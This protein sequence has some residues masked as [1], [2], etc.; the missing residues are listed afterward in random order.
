[1]ISGALAAAGISPAPLSLKVERRMRA[2]I[3]GAFVA[4]L[5]ILGTATPPLT[6]A[7]LPL[8]FVQDQA[9]GGAPAPA[10]NRPLEDIFEE[11]GLPSQEAAQEQADP[12]I[13][14]LELDALKSRGI[15][16][17]GWIEAG[18]GANNWGS[19]FNGPVTLAD[20][21]WQGQM[22]QLYLVNEKVIDPDNSG[23]DWGA[24]VD[25]LY[26]TDSIFTT[27]RGLDAYGF[28]QYGIINAAS[29]PSSKDYGLAMPQ[30]YGEIARDDLAVR[31]GHFYTIIGY[32]VVPAIG[33]F[34]YTHA[35]SMQY[36]PFTHTGALSIWTPG[37]QL[38]VYAGV[39]NGW[40]NFSDGQPVNGAWAIQN[41][42]YPGFSNN[43]AFLGGVTL[44]SSDQSQS[45]T[46][47]TS[48]GN[49]Y[50]PLGI[51]PSAGS[52]A[53]NRSIISTVY[54]NTLTDKLTYVFQND[55]G[56]QFNSGYPAGNLGQQAGLAQWYSFNQY[57]FW[58]FNEKWVG[59]MRLEY[60]RDN[61]GYKVTAPLRNYCQAG[62]AG[63]YA[64]GFAGNFW[65]MTFGLNYR[66]NRNWLVRPELRYDWFTPNA[67][68][69]GRPYG[70][71]LGQGIGSTGDKLGQLYAGCDAIFQF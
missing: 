34:F 51:A 44:K 11:R 3:C 68:V 31:V 46:V 71:G 15:N 6:A 53:G 65:E 27:A 61:N 8:T 55:N 29:W 64:G 60:F 37:D 2:T 10:S 62:N 7:D 69:T 41:R 56:W 5:M 4:S 48:S 25:L 43:A 49:E 14:R 16:T 21:S 70:R 67:G 50:T 36:E 54:T 58:K 39:T 17:F 63:Y 28:Q 33:N 52:L 45:L 9:P 47:T 40:D 13:R 19:P 30:L 57:L 24:R 1:V 23:W 12:P 18:I 20:R 26:G 59:G 42:S 32:E 38:I 35:F 22:N 66:A